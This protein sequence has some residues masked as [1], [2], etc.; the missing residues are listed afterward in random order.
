ML[1]RGDSA[2]EQKSVGCRAQGPRLHTPTLVTGA[3]S[4]IP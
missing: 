2:L 1:S 4:A 3:V